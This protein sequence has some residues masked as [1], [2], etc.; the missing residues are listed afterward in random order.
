MKRLLFGVGYLFM[1]CVPNA[2]SAVGQLDS[3]GNAWNNVTTTASCVTSNEIYL[4]NYR[5][6][7]Q[8]FAQYNYVSGPTPIPETLLSYDAVNW[9][10]IGAQ[11]G[12]GNI[13]NGVINFRG[14]LVNDNPSAP[15]IRFQM[16]SAVTGFTVSVYQTR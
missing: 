2:F 16:C 13:S 6:T 4:G 8:I 14:A 10:N 5:T 9:I 1:L 12:G 7:I 3:F 15:W 11:L